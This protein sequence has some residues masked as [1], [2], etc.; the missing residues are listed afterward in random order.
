[1]GEDGHQGEADAGFDVIVPVRFYWMH[2]GTEWLKKL[3]HNS[4]F[5]LVEG[6][7]VRVRCMVH[8]EDGL[9]PTPAGLV[10]IEVE[11]EFLPLDVALFHQFLDPALPDTIPCYADE[12][13]SKRFDK[14]LYA[15]NSLFDEGTEEFKRSRHYYDTLRAGLKD[16]PS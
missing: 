10:L 8:E 16:G 2:K 7:P 6:E 1:M 3:P 14:L 4:E 11:R 12:V 15:K 9:L 5:V 13:T